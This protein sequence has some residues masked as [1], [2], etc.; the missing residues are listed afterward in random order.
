M[1]AKSLQLHL[2]LSDPMDCS[3]PGSSVHGILQTR[4]LECIAMLFS[5][6]FFLTQGS[7]LHLMFPGLVSGFFTTGN[8]WKAQDLTQQNK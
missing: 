1:H 5:L 8:T 3:L 4:I 6:W 2:T 7:N